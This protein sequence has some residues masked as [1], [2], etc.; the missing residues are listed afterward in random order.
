MLPGGEP[1]GG[2]T[3]DDIA[4]A[5]MRAALG[6]VLVGPDVDPLVQA[7]ELR[8]PEPTSGDSFTRP[9]MLPLQRSIWPGIAP[10]A[11]V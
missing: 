6:G 9:A 8:I 10:G 2:Q 7:A 1:G 3:P 4:W 11:S 5:R